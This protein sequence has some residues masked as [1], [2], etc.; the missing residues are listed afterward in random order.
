[1]DNTS[2]CENEFTEFNM[3][4]KIVLSTWYGIAGLVAIIGNAVVLWLIFSYLSHRSISKLFVASLAVADFLVG[5]VIAPVWI[6]LRCL[7]TD[8]IQTYGETIDYLWIHTTVATTFNLC[9]VTLDRNIA[10]FRPL[11]YQ[12]IL[13]ERRCY[14]AIATVWFM[15]LVLPCSRFLVKESSAISSLWMSFTVITVLIP[16][17][18]IVISS[19]RIMKAAAQQSNRIP[20]ANN[21]QKQDAIK[22]GK[23]NY[24]AAKTVS[25][26]VGLF[27]VCWLPSLTTSFLNYL[28]QSD[29]CNGLYYYNIVWPSVEV[30]AFT[31]SGINPWVYCLRNGEFYQALTR[32]LR[33]NRNRVIDFEQNQFYLKHSQVRN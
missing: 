12:D 3:P 8:D 11:R 9:C 10:I 32:S 18:I 30:V 19:V 5:L 33:L 16:M 21:L 22:R 27:V 7:Y 26:V 24:K 29:H 31:S 4:G 13:S 14:A 15:S 25:I 20:P 1:M 2:T 28:T 17:I 23:K 6:V